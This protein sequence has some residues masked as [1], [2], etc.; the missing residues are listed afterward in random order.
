MHPRF[1]MRA[2][3]SGYDQ[4]YQCEGEGEHPVRQ[5]LVQLTAEAF[6]RP[7]VTR[8][9]LVWREKETEARIAR[10][11]RRFGSLLFRHGRKVEGIG[12]E[13]DDGDLA[14]RCFL[15]D[16]AVAHRQRRAAFIDHAFLGVI[17]KIEIRIAAI[18]D[19]QAL[20]IRP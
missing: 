11:K 7:L 17:D 10:R 9:V 6:G 3:I 13:L 1:T 20:R 19:E 15:L 8:V 16:F 14:I 4:R 12:Q 5:A 18:G 2:R